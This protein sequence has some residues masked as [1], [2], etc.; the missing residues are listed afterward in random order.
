M[1]LEKLSTEQHYIKVVISREGI[2]VIIHLSCNSALFEAGINV[3]H[4]VLIRH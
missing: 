4:N 1:Y 3:A 2:Y